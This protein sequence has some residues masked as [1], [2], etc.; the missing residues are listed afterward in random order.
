M[1][2]SKTVPKH[3]LQDIYPLHQ[4]T[5]IQH[6]QVLG[7]SLV[8]ISILYLVAAN[9]FMLPQMMQLAIPPFFLFLS[10]IASSYTKDNARL[11]QT[12]DAISGLM[13]GLSLAVIGQV[14]QTGADSFQLFLVWAL[15]LLPWLYRPNIGVFALFCI[16]SLL[17]LIL[18]F[19][20]TFWVYEHEILCLLIV[21]LWT[22]GL[23]II[24]LKFYPPL[25][26]ALLFW[27]A[28]LSIASMVSFVFRQHWH[29][30]YLALS[31][32][33]PTASFLYFHLKQQSLLATISILIIGLNLSILIIYGIAQSFDGSIVGMLMGCAI[34]IFAWFAVLASLLKKLFPQSE[35]NVIPLAFG[36]W[37]AGVLLAITLLVAWEKASLFFALIA[38]IS[39]LVGLKESKHLFARQFFYCLLVCGQ[40]G[41]FAHLFIFLESP[42]II[43]ITQLILLVIML[44]IF[45]LHWFVISLQLIALYF[46]AVFNIV[47]L[48]DWNSRQ[49]EIIYW[50][51]LNFAFYSVIFW[52]ASIKDQHYKQSIFLTLL[53]IIVATIYANPFNY[54]LSLHSLTDLDLQSGL[55]IALACIWVM[56]FF[57]L[58]IR[59]NSNVYIQL[60][61]LGFSLILILCGYFEILILF[62]ILAWSLKEK[63]KLIY[64][65]CL[66]SIIFFLW[67]L[68]YS[69]AIPFLLKSLSLFISGIVVL[70][71]AYQLK[72]GSNQQG[73]AS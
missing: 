2:S 17:A 44:S 67:S 18:Y 9:W 47:D 4:K 72:I 37:F 19:E 14:Y 43:L 21:N 28:L 33:L 56:V 24:S 20:Q 38:L 42:I 41:F 15:L 31:L 10:A 63:H 5:F 12:F 40:I 45:K 54:A 1:I 59:P 22:V 69:L 26:W 27:I 51:L 8:A 30:G 32:T 36:A 7:L 55:N 61:F 65:L 66:A 48:H 39:A 29:L 73:E 13:V 46:I 68:Y 50:I 64:G 62:I 11:R 34:V 58:V 60:G 53:T 16:T 57:F 35:F 23:F 71:F 70:A 3:L 49:T 25:R 52:M 6:L